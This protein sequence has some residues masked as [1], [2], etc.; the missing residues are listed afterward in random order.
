LRSI[1]DEVCAGLGAEDRETF[2][3]LLYKIAEGAKQA[4]S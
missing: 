2:L 1:D 3:R 4:E